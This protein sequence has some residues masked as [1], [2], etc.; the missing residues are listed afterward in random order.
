MI[1]RHETYQKHVDPTGANVGP[2]ETNNMSP[3]GAN[4]P[5]GTD[6]LKSRFPKGEFVF[7]GVLNPAQR[8][9]SFSLKVTD[10]IIGLLNSLKTGDR[11]GVS[12]S[13]KDPSKITLW[14]IK[15]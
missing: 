8:S 1:K 9:N 5:A 14:A 3:A 4:E 2:K 13:K 12:P 6:E 10:Q 7:V 15:D 11:I